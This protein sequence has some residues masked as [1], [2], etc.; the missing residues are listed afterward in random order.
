MQVDSHASRGWRVSRFYIAIARLPIY[1][2]AKLQP[3]GGGLF[4]DVAV[5]HLYDAFA[6]GRGLGVVSDH[7]DGLIEPVIQ[8]L[9]HVKDQG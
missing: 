8:L 1:F 5:A 3:N 4:H 9:E 2:A 6:H 7:N